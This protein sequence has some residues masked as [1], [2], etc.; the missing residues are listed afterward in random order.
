M[1]QKLPTPGANITTNMHAD[2][3]MEMEIHCSG[4]T[5]VKFLKLRGLMDLVGSS[6]PPPLLRLLMD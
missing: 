2:A 4:S 1:D 5:G 6:G 3:A